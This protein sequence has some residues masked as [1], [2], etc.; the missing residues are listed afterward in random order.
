MCAPCSSLLLF[1]LTYFQG[2]LYTRFA[3]YYQRRQHHFS[4]AM[5]FCQCAISLAISTQNTI[6]HSDALSSLAWT[7]WRLGDYS[8]TLVH[9]REAGRLARIFGD[10]FRE[11]CAL[12]IEATCWYSF[13][14]ER[15]LNRLIT[16][17]AML[18]SATIRYVLWPAKC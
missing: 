8:A 16:R 6:R 10:L 1:I 11:A 7:N 4:T 12:N 17:A 13:G 18:L 15:Q 9:G 2:T 14:K 3:D 5:N